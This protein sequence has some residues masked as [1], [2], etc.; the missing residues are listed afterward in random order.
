MRTT[1]ASGDEQDLVSCTAAP[2]GEA[3]DYGTDEESAQRGEMDYAHAVL[4]CFI[5]LVIA[6]I[7][8]FFVLQLRK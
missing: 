5:W 3:D 8:A 1:S 4:V 7:G 6:A 2:S